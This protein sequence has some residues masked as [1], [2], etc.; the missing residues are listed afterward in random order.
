VK[1]L[2]VFCLLL[3][4]CSTGPRRTSSL[5]TSG[6]VEPDTSSD[7]GI[8]RKPLAMVTYE[9][10][11]QHLGG[12]SHLSEVEKL[13]FWETVRGLD[14]VWTGIITEIGEP[15]ELAIPVRLRVGR[16]SVDWDTIVFFDP[17]TYEKLKWYASGDTISFR[18]SLERYEN[19]TIGVQVTVVRG[20]FAK[21]EEASGT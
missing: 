5:E 21:M 7:H 14:V 17:E 10:I 1:K 13:A 18:G 19:T 6:P 2:A 4:S 8:Y 3:L 16:K 9:V 12:S 11:N 15:R 20:H